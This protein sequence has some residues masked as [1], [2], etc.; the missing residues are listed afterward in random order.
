[1]SINY[2]YN[3]QKNRIP[4][5]GYCNQNT[6]NSYYK[7]ERNNYLN[8]IDNNI[9]TSF[10]S[11]NK[12]NR[13]N[14][15][16]SSVNRNKKRV[17]SRSPCSCG[18]HSNEECSYISDNRCHFL[19]I[20]N[21]ESNFHH[22]NSII[23]KNEEV[24]SKNN[25]LLNEV[26]N[27]KKNLK[28]IEN[29]LSRTKKENE[30]CNFYIKELERE[31]SKS[32]MNNILNE[33]DNTK[34][35]LNSVKTRDFGRYHDMLN[36]SF[37]VLD[38]ISNQ[39]KDPKGKTEGGV[40]YYFDKNQ[41]YNMVIDTQKK[42][43]DN[44]PENIENYASNNNYA[45]N[46]G[47]NNDNNDYNYDSNVNNRH[48]N[49]FSNS[50][51]KKRVDEL[52]NRNKYDNNNFYGGY[53]ESTIK[54]NQINSN[55]LDSF[56]DDDSKLNV[57]KYPEGYI[58]IKDINN[59]KSQSSY[60]I[61]DNSFATKKSNIAMN[62]KDNN[63]F[64]N[65]ISN[66][67]NSY[68]KLNYNANNSFNKDENNN[69]NQ[70]RPDR[71]YKKD[72]FDNNKTYTSYPAQIKQKSN[73]MKDNFNNKIP[74]NPNKQKKDSN[75]LQKSNKSNKT[76]TIPLSKNNKTNK[77]L[78][79]YND[80]NNN[81]NKE[82]ISENPNYAPILVTD[83]NGNPIY[84]EGQK[85]VGMEI[86]PIIRKDGKEEL[87]ENGNIVFLG[88]DGERKTQDDL[89]PIILDN[90]KP[91][92][93]EDNKPFLG[94]NGIVMVNRYGNP[95]V[96]PG[97]LYDKNEKVVQGIIGIVPT[98][99][100]G[101]SIKLNMGENPNQ[102]DNEEN[103]NENNFNNKHYKDSN[104]SNNEDSLN[105]NNNL[106][107]DDFNSQYATNNNINNPNNDTKNF[108]VN[109]NENDND[110]DNN[111]I[112]QDNNNYHNILENNKNNFNYNINIKPLI[113]SDGRPVID[114]KNNPIML[115]ENNKPI[116]GTG[117]TI[118]LDQS[119]KPLLNTIGEP[120]LINKEG[121][122]INLI[123]N[124]KNKNPINIYCPNNN[125]RGEIPKIN[126]IKRIPNK[127]TN[128]DK[129]NKNY[130]RLNYSFNDYENN[131][132]IYPKINQNYQRKLNYLPKEG[133]I[134]DQNKYSSTCFACDVGCAVSRSGYSPMTYSP[135]N[136]RIKRRE[137][138][139][140]RNEI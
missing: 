16:D 138:T 131:N 95:I 75:N 121:K 122:P 27:L 36:K 116:K 68:N 84:I 50:N 115:D 52:N 98:D 21:R 72:N 51:C 46:I 62:M 38:S 78:P 90:D 56:N 3:Y 11:Y 74:R 15:I 134:F 82:E 9:S 128:K 101:N 83:R 43:I 76:N 60:N 10:S 140:L 103:I 23:T 124:K 22:Y 49:T 42:F 93:N 79:Q 67:K 64:D 4:R 47:K 25:D 100:Q 110:N 65:N 71:I 59:T 126:N 117:I 91:L 86:V 99:N 2:P 26:I 17:V 81:K 18:C 39:C 125:K 6:N 94:I 57:F 30:A 85:L 87:D 44:L 104:N 35:I 48:N 123:N 136:N 54:T 113:G 127:K 132:Y 69:E 120:I 73:S 7:L 45:N 119:G 28:K 133:K 135:Y 130:E 66:K 34:R 33:N 96:G 37:E 70:N 12:Y 114:K 107:E 24:N 137:V 53:N 14:N 1:M 63:N 20:L 112:N 13:K 102:V 55:K 97:Q 5:Y 8:S 41:E 29:E 77:L 19:P 40:N 58:N 109:N 89:E 61:S 139:P 129:E 106:N 32:N 118:L 31:L 92:V 108:K 111:N 88:P 105:Y 80:M